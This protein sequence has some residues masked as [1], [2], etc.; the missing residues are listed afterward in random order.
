MLMNRSLRRLL[1]ALAASLVFNLVAHAIGLFTVLI[2]PVSAILLSLFPNYGHSAKTALLTM[3][4]PVFAYTVLFWTAG[5]VWK[6]L[7]EAYD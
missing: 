4:A 1:L 5:T 2:F 7:R 6:M 3:F